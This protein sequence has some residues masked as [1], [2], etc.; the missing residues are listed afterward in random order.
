MFIID[1]VV[2]DDAVGQ[3]SFCCDIKACRG[4]CC[5]IE[6]GRGAPLLD[7]EVEEIKNAY[8]VII[9][10]LSERSIRAIAASGLYDG[11]PG[12][13]ATTCIDNRD[14]V[15]VHYEGDIARCSFETA[16]GAGEL[17]WRKPLSCH[18][19]PVR[20]Q[21]FGRDHLRYEVIDECR[22]GRRLGEVTRTHL[23]DFL[24]EPLTR[25]YGRQWYEQFLDYCRKEMDGT[26]G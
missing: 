5:C 8:P 14:C 3:A 4:A 23:H 20:V 21:H 7:D 22:A 15:F 2:V 10:Y 24:R 25:T 19:F 13:F 16:F 12:R 9:K 18:L 26:S 17:Q 1:E 6:G 11:A